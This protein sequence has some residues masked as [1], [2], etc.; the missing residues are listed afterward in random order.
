MTLCLYFLG[1]PREIN[2]LDLPWHKKVSQGSVISQEVVEW[3][4]GPIHPKA[5][6]SKKRQTKCSS[7]LSSS[8]GVN[9][10]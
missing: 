4:S 9:G 5:K 3:S 6:K 7:L 1:I 8:L 10:P 2:F